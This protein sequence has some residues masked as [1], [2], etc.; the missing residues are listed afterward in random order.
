MEKTSVK[1]LLSI[2]SRVFVKF[3]SLKTHGFG[4]QQAPLAVLAA[5]SHEQKYSTVGF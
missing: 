5:N 3:Q 4:N 1:D 2:L